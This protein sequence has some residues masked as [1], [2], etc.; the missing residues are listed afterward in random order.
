V[1][2]LERAISVSPNRESSPHRYRSPTDHTC[3]C[4]RKKEEDHHLHTDETKITKAKA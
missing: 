2:I 4:R 3:R 1:S